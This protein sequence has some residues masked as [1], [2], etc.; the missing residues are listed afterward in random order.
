MDRAEAHAERIFHLDENGK[1]VVELAVLEQALKAPQFINKKV[2][3][4]TLG[5]EGRSGKSFLLNYIVRFFEHYCKSG[6]NTDVS[7]IRTSRSV[8]LTQQP[9]TDKIFSLFVSLN[10]VRSDKSIDGQTRSM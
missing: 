10:L 4:I 3:V 5:G 2:A 9:L 1:Y 6:E 8:Q 7:L